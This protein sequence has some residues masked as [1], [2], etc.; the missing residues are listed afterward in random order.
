P[1]T[2]LWRCFR[3]L[4]MRREIKRAARLPFVSFNSIGSSIT[5]AHA[6]H[7][8][9]GFSDTGALSMD[10]GAQIAQSRRSGTLDALQPFLEAILHN[11]LTTIKMHPAVIYPPAPAQTTPL[12]SQSLEKI[13]EGIME[14]QQQQQ[15]QKQQPEQRKQT[16]TCLSCG[17]PKSCYENDG[18]SH[19][20]MK[21]EM[22]WKEFQK[23]AFY[24]ME[25][26]RWVAERRKQK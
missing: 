14:R 11:L 3:H 24:E 2:L 10:S 7:L 12:T 26:Q 19:Q 4:R 15:Q 6:Q 8:E 23:Y 25:R 13:V 21:K 1:L 17:Q 20:G 22:T 9:R 5:V 18:S 16:K